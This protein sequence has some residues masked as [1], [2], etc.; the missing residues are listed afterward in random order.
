MNTYKK[1]I[2][3]LFKVFFSGRKLFQLA[4]Q[5]GG[6]HA[7]HLF[8]NKVLTTCRGERHLLHVIYVILIP[9]C[10]FS[11]L[12]CPAAEAVGRIVRVGW[13]HSDDSLAQHGYDAEYLQALRQFTGWRYV[14]VDGSWEECLQRLETGEIDILSFVQKT[15]A[16]EKIYGYPSLPMATTSGYLV[17]DKRRNLDSITNATVIRV[18]I[19]DG[20]NFNADFERYRQENNL[21]V[22]YVNLASLTDVS[23]ALANGSIDAAV[24]A[25]E[26]KTANERV[27]VRLASYDQYFVTNINNKSLLRELDDGMMQ[28]STYTPYFNG[29]L[30]RK[31]FANYNSGKPVFTLAEQEFIKKHPKILVLSDSRW[32]PIEYYDKVS[33]TFK[34]VSRDIFAL[35]SEKCGIEFVYDDSNS[36][37]KMSEMSGDDDK[38]RNVL[39]TTSYD[40]NWAEKHHMYITQP[41]ITSNMVKFGRRL[42]KEH[43]IVAVNTKA[44]FAYLLADFLKDKKI[45]SYPNTDERLEAVIRGEAD[46]TVLTQDQAD[47]YHSIP[48]YSNFSTERLIGYEQRICIAARMDC[49]PELISILCKTIA[50]ISHDELNEIIRKNTVEVYQ[51]SWQDLIYKYRFLIAVAI[52]GI[53]VVILS[54]LY[55]NKNRRRSFAAIK[56]ALDIKETALKEAQKASKAKGSFM[57]SMSHE[58]RTP[59]NAIIGYINLSIKGLQKNSSSKDKESHAQTIDYLQK[60]NI[61]SRHLLTVINDVLDMSAIESGKLKIAADKFS[62]FDV[63][64]SIAA[65]FAPEAAAKEITYRVDG[66]DNLP[67]SL[68]G[69]QLRVRQVLTNLISN[70]IK[71]TPAKGLVQLSITQLRESTENIW[72]RF[73]VKDTGIG[74][75]EEYLSHL[76]TPFEQA[77]SSISRRFGGTGLGLSITKGLV[78]AMGGSIRAESIINQGTTF[79]VELPFGRNGSKGEEKQ[80]KAKIE[81]PDFSN[82]RALLA[83]DNEMNME[84]AC[85]ILQETGLTIE[86]AKN[87]R[88][89]CEMFNKA[90]PGYYQLILMDVRMPEMDGYEATRQIRNSE[91]PEG[92]S[93]PIIAMTADAFAENIAESMAV[94]MN[95]HLA[96]PLQLDKLFAVL[97]KYIK[98]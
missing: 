57:A 33:G 34:G 89:A 71:F 43:P 80:E 98:K 22:E 78:E 60:S 47:Y 77:D 31:Y 61:A 23:P 45:I 59:L 40:Y 4:F 52:G 26:D 82:A 5:Q 42:D 10:F 18:G 90:E 83:E 68:I 49:D 62:F 56:Q 96:K 6:R 3:P 29:Y 20:N 27:W 55:V 94:G 30:Y 8:S 75:T 48:R 28:I 86:C 50:C 14:Y 87:G 9:V 88:E 84:I 13:C 85:A 95:D 70:A 76:W 37:K 25:E 79:T 46:Y 54:L 15:P 39:T 58:I 73:T 44:Y 19:V 65:V 41:F 97:A 32:P 93:I 72:L 66:L 92:K 7:R 21:Q 64:D 53:T 11:L 91:H 51:L 69:D 2:T 74:M 36:S 16:R 63:L 1:F 12:D 17:V 38:S 35:L 24:V 67:D 81:L